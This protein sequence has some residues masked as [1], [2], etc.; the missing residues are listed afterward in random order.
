MKITIKDMIPDDSGKIRI[1]FTIDNDDT[2][3]LLLEKNDL[4]SLQTVE[5]VVKDLLKGKQYIGQSFNI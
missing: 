5:N 4:S 1:Y 2:T 3:S